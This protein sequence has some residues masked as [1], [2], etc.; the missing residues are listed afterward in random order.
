M[1][2]TLWNANEHAKSILEEAG[3]DEWQMQ[4]VFHTTKHGLADIRWVDRMIDMWYHVSVSSRKWD[5]NQEAQVWA[6]WVKDEMRGAYA[7]EVA[8]V[9]GMER[10][11]VKPKDQRATEGVV[12]CYLIESDGLE[13]KTFREDGSEETVIKAVP[14]DLMT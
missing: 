6:L 5:S 8:V 11:R 12:Q 13:V 10:E 7:T 2:G 1:F 4:C 14:W 3:C 9:K